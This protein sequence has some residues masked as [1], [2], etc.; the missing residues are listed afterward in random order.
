MFRMIIFFLNKNRLLDKKK[1][2][3]Q[4]GVLSV[5]INIIDNDWNLQ[6]INFAYNL[7][8][9]KKLPE[10]KV[11]LYHTPLILQPIIF[12]AYI[13][14]HFR[15]GKIA[16][17]SAKLMEKMKNSLICKKQSLISFKKINLTHLNF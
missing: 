6:L 14:L 7:L 13:N 11:V 15:L 8:E 5:S 12:I 1:E 3:N 16:Q 10:N 17:N 2:E 9:Y 4:K